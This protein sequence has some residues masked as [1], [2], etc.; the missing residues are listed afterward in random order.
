MEKIENICEDVM[1]VLS[2]DSVF[3]YRGSLFNAARQWWLANAEKVKL[4]D[5]VMALVDNIVSEVYS[6]DKKAWQLE[7]YS[8]K[9]ILHFKDELWVFGIKYDSDDGEY[10]KSMLAPESIREKYLR[11]KYSESII[12]GKQYSF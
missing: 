11:K 8:W 12:P 1:L 3:N 9:D 10:C 6:P 5:Y 7:K 2:K 4:A